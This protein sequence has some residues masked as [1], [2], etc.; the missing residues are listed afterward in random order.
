M[1]ERTIT[2]N[3]VFLFFYNHS[4]QVLVA[5]ILFSNFCVYFS[6]CVCVISMFCLSICTKTV[7]IMMDQFP[8]WDYIKD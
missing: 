3:T 5:S 7:L 1:I 2:R 8:T 4:M 6:V